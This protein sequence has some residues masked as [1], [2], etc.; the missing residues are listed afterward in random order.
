MR[1]C[2]VHCVDR[3]GVVV[4]MQKHHYCQVPITGRIVH[5]PLCGALL[6]VGVQPL[7]H[8]EAAEGHIQARRREMHDELHKSTTALP[9][10]HIALIV[11]VHTSYNQP[12]AK[13]VG[14]ITTMCNGST[15]TA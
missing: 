3:A 10:V 12:L 11:S 8:L 15:H 2:P 5:G 13:R 6:T 9:S 4:L 7:D 1:R 14:A